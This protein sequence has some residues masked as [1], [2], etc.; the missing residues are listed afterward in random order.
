M[1]APEREAFFE[2]FSKKKNILWSEVSLG[3]VGTA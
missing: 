3:T 2:C 1:E